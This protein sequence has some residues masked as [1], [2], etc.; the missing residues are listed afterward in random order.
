MR[1]VRGR[2]GDR[3]SNFAMDLRCTNHSERK[4]TLYLRRLKVYFET[5]AS[6]QN[7][8]REIEL[9]SIYLFIIFITQVR[10]CFCVALLTLMQD[11]R[12]SRLIQAPSSCHHIIRSIHASRLTGYTQHFTLR[13]YFI[14]CLVILTVRLNQQRSVQ[15]N[16]LLRLNDVL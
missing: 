1:F 16:C 10:I 14:N 8:Q 9:Y 6:H 11:T 7:N 13:N 4:S 12:R 15:M 5:V 3:S 2:S